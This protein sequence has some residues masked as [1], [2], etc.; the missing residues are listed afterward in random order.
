LSRKYYTTPLPPQK[1]Q[2]LRAIIAQLPQ[3]TTGSG[4]AHLPFPPTSSPPPLHIITTTITAAAACHH[5]RYYYYSST[6][7]LLFIMIIITAGFVWVFV[8]LPAKI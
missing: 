2:V 7:S 5:H 1:V 6:T 3:T 8:G 4:H